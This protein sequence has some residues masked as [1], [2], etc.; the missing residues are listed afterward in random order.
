[1]LLHFMA[2]SPYFSH[3]SLVNNPE[4]HPHIIATQFV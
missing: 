2:I 3:L 4:R 1:M